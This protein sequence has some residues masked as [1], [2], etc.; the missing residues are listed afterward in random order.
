MIYFI[1]FCSQVAYMFIKILG[2]R[3]MVKN[4]LPRRL[5][6]TSIANIVWLIT[7]SIGVNQMIQGNYLI[8]VPYVIGSLL[9]VILEDKIRHKY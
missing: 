1:V 6:I 7:T 5:L 3:Y 2:V 4:N 8:I 9:G